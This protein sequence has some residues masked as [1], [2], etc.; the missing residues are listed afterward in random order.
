M[1]TVR[2]LLCLRVDGRLGLHPDKVGVVGK[3]DR[4][5]D[6]ALGT[7]LVSVEALPSSW[8]VPRPVRCL[9]ETEALGEREGGRVG[10]VRGEGL[11][12][13]GE[14]LLGLGFGET[15]LGHR[16]SEDVGVEGK[17]GAL[18]PFVL[19]LLKLGA[20]LALHLG[21]DHDLDERGERGVGGAEDE[22]LI[23]RVDVGGDEGSCFRVGTGD[24]EVG[25]AHDVALEAHGDETVDVFRDGYEHLKSAM[26]TSEAYLSSHVS[27]LLGPR[28]LIFDMNTRR[29]A[30]H[31]H[32]GE[33]H[34]RSQTCLS[35]GPKIATKPLTSVTGISVRDNRPKVVYRLA[36]LGKLSFAA[37]LQCAAPGPSL[38]AVVEE[39]SLKE[40]GDLV[41]DG[42][43]GVV[44]SS[45]EI[46]S[47]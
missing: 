18:G 12:D 35:A 34:H 33:L 19:D 39:L 9:L 32:L 15:L 6:G 17:V 31:H 43:G 1:H 44:C 28:R 20:R 36:D 13:L 14:E 46:E 41:G 45:A 21:L 24:D 26:S 30:L 29:T 7:A 8:G 16:R 37:L 40:L 38:L 23:A 4:P 25:R 42:I 11:A 22:G 3:R 27:A 5:V 10:A 47:A 2:K